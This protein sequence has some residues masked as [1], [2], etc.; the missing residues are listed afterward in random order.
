MRVMRACAVGAIARASP[1]AV[2]QVVDIKRTLES[3]CLVTDI[4]FLLII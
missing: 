4:R 3:L 2:R 1:T